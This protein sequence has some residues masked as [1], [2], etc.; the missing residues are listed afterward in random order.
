MAVLP[1]TA[2][3]TSYA[4]PPAK[5]PSEAKPTATHR[6]PRDGGDDSS[7]IHRQLIG[8]IGLLLPLLLWLIAALRPNDPAHRWEHLGSISAYYYT[9]A[10]AAFIGLLIALAL[11]LYAYQGFRNKYQLADK[12]TAK[13]AATAALGVAFFPSSPP[14]GMLPTW[15][16]IKL[17]YVHYISAGIL[18]ACFAV[19]SLWLFGLTDDNKP[20]EQD[21]GWRNFLYR[22]CGL[23][24]LIGMGWAYYAGVVNHGPIFWPEFLMLGSFALSWLLKGSIHKT[25]AE[26]IK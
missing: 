26:A 15:Y 21:K 23:G 17:V 16:T 11:Y 3:A 6:R 24:I 22:L 1:G 19:F 10:V 14:T 18:F 25:I 5:A 2:P 4:P 9:G 7:R 20:R 8:S 13:I 12:L